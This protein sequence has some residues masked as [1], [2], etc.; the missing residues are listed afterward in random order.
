MEAELGHNPSF[1]WRS[2]LAA[3]EF[4]REGSTWKIG[5]GQSVEVSDKT[6]LPQP[7]L[8]KPGANTK[9]KVGDLID[10][11]TMQ[12]NRSL[13]QATFMQPTQTAI[14]RTQLSNIRARD[15]LCW[16]EN[17]TQHF[18]IKT[19]Y[20]VALRMQ[21]ETGAEHSSVRDDKRFWSRI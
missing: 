20:Q 13:I 8:F 18:T 10:Q 7:P 17:K 14:L 2:L 6:W 21:R 3:R 4:I 11:Q 1:V 15:K 16:K 5:N 19:A 9:M 12:W